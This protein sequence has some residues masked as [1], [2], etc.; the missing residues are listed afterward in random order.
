MASLV[1][2]NVTNHFRLAVTGLSKSAITTY[3]VLRERLDPKT[4]ERVSVTPAAKARITEKLII[5]TP[6]FFTGNDLNRI[7]A[8]AATTKGRAG[9]QPANPRRA[10]A[11][12]YFRKVAY[13]HVAYVE[14]VFG[15]SRQLTLFTNY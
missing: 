2:A 5:S 8:S 7:F 12:S 4:M 9:V 14:P 6:A 10:R 13:T 1:V 3:D 15:S 11:A